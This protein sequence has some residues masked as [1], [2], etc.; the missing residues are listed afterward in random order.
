MYLPRTIKVISSYNV[1]FDESFS[2][3]LSYTSQPYS[4]VMAMRPVVTYTLYAKS[5]KEQTGDVITFS[6]FEE[7]NVL[8]ETRNDAESV[9]ESDKESILMSE[10]DM[11]NID[12]NENSNHDIISTEMLK[13]IPDGSQ[14][15]PTVNKREAR[16][17]IRDCVR[18]RQ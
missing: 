16:C 15:D 18:Q 1:V 14:T 17:K 3:V 9:D 12:S 10:Q 11:E 13:D 7:G 6:Q 8:T 4:E 2:S 5:S